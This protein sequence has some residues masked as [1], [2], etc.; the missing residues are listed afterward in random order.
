MPIFAEKTHIDFDTLGISLVEMECNHFGLLDKLLSGFGIPHAVMSDRDALMGIARGRIECKTVK[1]KTSPVFCSLSKANH[2]TTDDEKKISDAQSKILKVGDKETYPNKLFEELRDIAEL[3]NVYVLS[4]NFE[5]VL[6]QQG[7]TKLLKKASSIA[8]SKVI[9]GRFVAEEIVKNNK[10]IPSEFL[11][12][13]SVL[14]E[15]VTPL[16]KSS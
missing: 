15:F 10:E 7:Y 16:V 12:V 6:K 1:T 8:N 2:L 14:K 4:S 13:L 9:Q 3:H 11:T 5:G